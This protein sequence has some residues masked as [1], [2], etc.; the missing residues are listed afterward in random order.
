MPVSNTHPL[1]PHIHR[2][3]IEVGRTI[4]SQSELIETLGNWL[5]DQGVEVERITT[6]T[7]ILHP[8]LF[9]Y[10]VL[11]LLGEKAEERHFIL[12]A[13]QELNYQNSAVSLIY[14]GSTTV[15]R[16]IP[17][18]AQADD[19]SIFPMLRETGFTD[20]MA[21]P[22]PFS[23]GS[24][25]VLTFA[26]KRS[27]GFAEKEVALLSSL[28][29]QLAPLVEILILQQTAR[30]FLNTYLGKATGERVRAGAIKR[31]TYDRIEA[32]IWFCDLRD[33]TQLS[34]QVPADA[35]IELLNQYL[36]CV[37]DAIESEGGEVLKYV[38]DAV[39]AIFPL[40]GLNHESQAKSALRAAATALTSLE[41]FNRDRLI[42]NQPSLRF[43]IA[44]HKGEVLYGN[45]GG[46]D[47]LDFTVI[48]PAVNL[49]SRLEA[50]TK[51]TGRSIHV[52]E[53]FVGLCNAETVA[54][55]EDMGLRT[56]KGISDPQRVFAVQRDHSP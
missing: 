42:V 4:P 54:R 38:G 41:T 12:T 10:S 43:G 56:L 9:S 1:T 23:D 13:E 33:F 36:E 16:R 5:N 53:A 39:M 30:T 50:L 25:K 20:Y 7:P 44:L 51:E 26:T 6:G 28:G 18:D 3:M 14:N 22:M 31:G 47:R 45:I 21:V 2:W 46:R 49:A 24:Q 37:T 27:D 32:I 55:L 11:W 17:K 34:E 15:H 52:S 19:F 40:Q 48:G 35:L 29:P 8:L